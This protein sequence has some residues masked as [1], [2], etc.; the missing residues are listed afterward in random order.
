MKMFN[1]K[2]GSFNSKMR[3]IFLTLGIELL[4]RYYKRYKGVM[5]SE[6]NPVGENS[7]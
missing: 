1:L 3:D 4:G 5:R 2:R 6:R 7:E